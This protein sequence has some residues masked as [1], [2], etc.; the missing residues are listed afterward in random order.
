MSHF[1]PRGVYT[2]AP[3]A[4]SRCCNPGLRPGAKRT[5]SATWAERTARSGP[6]AYR[7]TASW[8]GFQGYPTTSGLKGRFTTA[9]V[10]GGQRPTE[11]WV[12]SKS[13]N[14]DRKP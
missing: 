4:T 2:V 3:R 9:Q 12:P 8:T 11:A 13:D 1:G 6:D 7:G 5:V 14:G 10:G